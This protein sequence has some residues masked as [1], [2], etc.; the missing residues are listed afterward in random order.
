[1]DFKKLDHHE[2]EKLEVKFRNTFIMSIFP[3]FDEATDQYD[4]EQRNH[5]L[6]NDVIFNKHMANISSTKRTLHSS[7]IQ[8]AT[9]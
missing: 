8:Y 7:T 3:T 9:Y 5:W 2:K 6:S 1:M 4:H